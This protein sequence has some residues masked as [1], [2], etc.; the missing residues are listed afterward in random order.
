[1]RLTLQM[2]IQMCTVK[3]GIIEGRCKKEIEQNI[4]RIPPENIHTQ[5]DR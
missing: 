5:A 1:M 4:K 2:C 3:E